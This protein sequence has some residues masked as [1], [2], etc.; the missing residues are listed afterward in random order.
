MIL[1]EPDELFSGP[2]L[3]GAAIV[4][5]PVSRVPPVKYKSFADGLS[6]IGNRAEI[7][8]KTLFLPGE[9]SIERM[10]KVV[11]P[12]RI[13]GVASHRTGINNADVFE[14]ALR[15][16]P[17]LAIKP[18]CLILECLRQF[19]EDVTSAEVVNAMYGI[20]AKRIQV[21]FSKPIEGIV[22]D[23]APDAVALRPVK[24]DRLSPGRV[25][26]IREAG[27]KLGKIIAL[28][29][30]MVVDHVQH[31]GEV[32]TMAGVHKLLQPGRTAVGRLWSVKAGT[33]VSP[34]SIPGHL[35]DRHD[36]NGGDAKITKIWK[37][38]NHTCKTPLGRECPGVKFV[39]YEVL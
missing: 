21:V 36:F 7:H 16:H 33:V 2:M 39:N 29:T 38:G 20:Q 3:R 11:V 26:G 10:M 6:Q 32:E 5:S 1:T 27:S 23:E 30:E 24:V 4:P 31:D 9:Q 14:I 15:D 19:L 18:A 13:Q 12:L 17:G 28:G 8:Q 37:A 34:I 22:D 25:M 35:C